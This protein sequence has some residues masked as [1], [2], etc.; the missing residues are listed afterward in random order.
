MSTTIKLTSNDKGTNVVTPPLSLPKMM[1]T[2]HSNR[3]RDESEDDQPISS[4]LSK[5]TRVPKQKSK[6]KQRRL[7]KPPSV[8]T[9]TD[10]SSHYDEPNSSPPSLPS[11]GPS[12]VRKQ[13]WTR[14]STNPSSQQ[15]PLPDTNLANT[16]PSI[17]PFS[18]F[19]LE[20]F[21]NFFRGNNF[22]A[23]YKTS[24]VK[25]PFVY[26]EMIDMFF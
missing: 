24:I 12:R 21:A 18:S 3:L 19:S 15:A 4:L 6:E 10:D 5:P 9:R 17:T 16:P 20:F 23:R 7:M 26:E 13:R 11:T 25:K 1:K 2:R 22:E 8:K 14:E